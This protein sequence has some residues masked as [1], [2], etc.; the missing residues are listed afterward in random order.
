MKRYISLLFLILL[1]LPVFAM[2]AVNSFF[3]SDKLKVAM[4]TQLADVLT[5]KGGFIDVLKAE[6]G[7]KI[8]VI[9]E[10]SVANFVDKINKGI[11]DVDVVLGIDNSVA[12]SVRSKFSDLKIFEYAFLTFCFDESSILVPPSSLLDLANMEFYDKIIFVDPRSSTLGHNLLEW[13]ISA[14]GE[15]DAFSWWPKVMANAYTVSPSWHAAYSIFLRGSAPLVVSYTTMPVMNYMSGD[16]KIRSL[17]LREGTLTVDDY[18]GVLKTTTKPE[19][20]KAFF[21]YVLKNSYKI[22]SKNFMYPVQGEDK[23][24]P[25]YQKIE[26]PT[27]ILH[28]DYNFS[29]DAELIEK[30]SEI[31]KQKR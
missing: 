25:E 19:E 29:R 23:L 17:N 28:N 4:T 27:K 6:T 2:Q 3:A 16:K 8:E 22:A 13:S 21:D 20:A 9:T 30:W 24:P 10:P 11:L 7:L 15:D 26:K 31:T 1:S 18:I 14:L 12:D 5:E